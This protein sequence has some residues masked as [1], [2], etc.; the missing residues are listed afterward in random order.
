MEKEARIS[1]APGPDRDLDRSPRDQTVQMPLG[2][3][4]LQL[5]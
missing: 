2:M 1:L 5:E 3:T 4:L